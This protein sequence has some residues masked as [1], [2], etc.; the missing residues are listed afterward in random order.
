MDNRIA[1]VLF[2]CLVSV[3]P[4]CKEFS[5]AKRFWRRTILFNS[6]TTC[7]SHRLRVRTLQSVWLN[8][9]SGVLAHMVQGGNRSAIR[10]ELRTFQV[11][12]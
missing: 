1:Y 5:G 10:N 3:S 8:R 11:R 6:R 4:G 2:V 9:S 12:L 7:N